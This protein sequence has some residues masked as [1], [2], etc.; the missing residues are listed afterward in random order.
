MFP[1]Q[2]VP[3]SRLCL[4]LLH[5][6]LWLIITLV[7]PHIPPGQLSLLKSDMHSQVQRSPSLF[8]IGT[9]MV[10]HVSVSNPRIFC[11]PCASVNVISLSNLQQNDQHNSVSTLVIEAGV[12]NIKTSSLK[13]S[14]RTSLNLLTLSWLP[15]SSWL[16]PGRCHHC[17][18][19]TLN[20][21]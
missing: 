19:V 12:N 2:Q 3:Q 5:R 7:A 21:V 15:G 20:S 16:F 10:R 11:H 4:L 6:N 14:K 17:V 8:V 18:L 1:S 13:S 9:L